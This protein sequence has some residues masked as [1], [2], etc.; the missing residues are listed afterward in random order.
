VSAAGDEIEQLFED[1]PC[2]YVT[3]TPDG[4]ITR[5]NRTFETLV[6][7]PRDELAGLQFQRLLAVGARIFYETH[8]APL[9]RMQGFAREIAVDLTRADGTTVPALLNATLHRDAAGAAVAI[10]TVVFE[11]TERRRYEQELVAA[12][13]RE[14]EIAG[15]LQRALLAGE[16][17]ADPALELAVSYRPAVAGLEVG[18]D[19]Y[20]AF[21]LGE[22]RMAVTVG[23][24]VGRGIGA[25]TA[26]GQLRS[27]VRAVAATGLGPGAVLEALDAYARR[28]GVGQMTTLSYAELDL[29]TGTLTSASAGHPPPAVA[30]PDAPAS[31]AWGGRSAPLDAELRPGPRAQATVALAPGSV[32]LLY[33]DGLVER[34]GRSIQDGLDVVLAVLEQ[35]R[36][37]PLRE[38]IAAVERAALD[39]E[40]P[41][42]DVC[43]LALR[44]DPRR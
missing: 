31:F 41:A 4:V 16:L 9:L 38:L 1:A 34:A 7:R 17:P 25:G 20:D 15:E 23:D 5:V 12:R 29:A 21:W 22:R 26:M 42:D 14:H 13:N 11:A 6:G 44:W 43:V 39:A 24:V 33:T 32:L 37:R 27:A 28:H 8:Y 3:T 40:S 2:G 19:W 35:E 18:G 36:D 10:R 30:P